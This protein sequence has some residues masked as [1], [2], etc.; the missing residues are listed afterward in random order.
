MRTRPVVSSITSA[1]GDLKDGFKARD[2]QHRDWSGLTDRERIGKGLELLADCRLDRSA[3][4]GQESGRREADHPLQH[5]P[6]GAAMI[7]HGSGG[8]VGF[9]GASGRVF[10][11]FH[12]S[13]ASEKLKSTLPR[14]PTKPTKPTSQVRHATVLCAACGHLSATALP[15]TVVEQELLCNFCGARRAFYAWARPIN[16]Q[17]LAPRAR[18][19]RNRAAAT[20]Q[21]RRK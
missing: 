18:P 3:G 13:S 20:R 17:H 4:R 1:A 11:E 6:T 19:P 2:I 16:W 15:E 9:V 5:Q 12:A 10:L 14:Q 21:H 8:F 7:A